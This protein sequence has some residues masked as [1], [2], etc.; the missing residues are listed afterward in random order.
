MIFDYGKAILEALLFAS[1][2]PLSLRR[3]TELMG[4]EERAARTLAE[5]LRQDY[6]RSGRGL[7]LLEVAGGYQLATRAEFDTYVSRLMPDRQQPGLSRA[8][9]ETLAVVAYHQPVTRAEVE[10]VRGVASDR[11][12]STLLEKGLI[13]E[14]GRKDAPGRPIFY[15]TTPLFLQHFG[16]GSLEDLPRLD[17]FPVSIEALEQSLLAA[18]PASASAAPPE[19]PAT[20]PEAPAAPARAQATPPNRSDDETPGLR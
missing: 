19:A 8:A 15:A 1:S 20:P 17:D 3:L 11:S 2:E 10:Q 12:L 16:L 7:A 4:V 18:A 9:L 6:E 14:A 5:E 13:E